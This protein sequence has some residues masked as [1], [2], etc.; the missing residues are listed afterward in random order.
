MDG[1]DAVAKN[2][3]KTS[4]FP[5]ATLGLAVSNPQI[6]CHSLPCSFQGSSPGGDPDHARVE[7]SSAKFIENFMFLVNGFGCESC[8]PQ[9]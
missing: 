7:D 3:G 8:L 6:S 2:T 1:R 5:A 4:A 9:L